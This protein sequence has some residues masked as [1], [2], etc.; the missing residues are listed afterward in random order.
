MSYLRFKHR[1]LNQTSKE[2][3][4]LKLPRCRSEDNI[5]IV[6]KEVE[7]EVRAGFKHLK[8]GSSGGHL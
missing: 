3:R 5:K 8:K 6:L 1:I 2:T 4:H 7:G